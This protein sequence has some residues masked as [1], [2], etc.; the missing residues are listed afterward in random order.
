MRRRP[1]SSSIP[2]DA[3]NRLFQHNRP[4]I[5]VGCI[6]D[7]GAKRT[8]LQAEKWCILHRFNAPYVAANDE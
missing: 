4:E 1:L 7:S 8:I 6:E 2:V 3:G 5:A